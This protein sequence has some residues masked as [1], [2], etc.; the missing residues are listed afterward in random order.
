MAVRHFRSSAIA[1]VA[2]NPPT[3]TLTT[4]TGVLTNDIIIIHVVS[5]NLTEA[6]NEIATPADYTEVSAKFEC[7]GAAAA[8]DMRSALFYKRS[9]GA[10]S[11]A[12]V[13]VSR[14]GTD[15][16]LLC[17]KAYVYRGCVTTGS[18]FDGAIVTNSDAASVDDTINFGTFTCTA[19]ASH[20]VCMG[21][22]ADDVSC[23]PATFTTDGTVFSLDGYSETT[24][25]T[26]ATMLAYSAKRTSAEGASGAV[27][28]DINSTAGCDLS[29]TFGL[30]PYTFDASRASIAALVDSAQA[31]ATGWDAV[32]KV[33]IDVG[34]VARTSDAAA[35]IT[36][37]AE[38]GYDITAQETVTPVAPWGATMGTLA[39]VTG[40][41]AF[42]VDFVGGG[43]GPVVPVFMA[44]YQQRR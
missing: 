22:H 5:K 34:D 10:D 37:D 38:A 14:A 1:T 3:M 36:L 7:D 32:V 2:A 35:T 42:T 8:D 20:V 43:G 12:A 29:Y 40:S 15:T 21:C 41:P 28:V 6:T 17:A 33:G 9:A 27:A 19:T 30:L 39:N 11:A 31:E 44:Q 26:D 25:G 13:T 23:P 4:P 16:V 18:P 24:T